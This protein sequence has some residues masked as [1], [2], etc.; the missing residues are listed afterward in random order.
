MAKLVVNIGV[1][2]FELYCI[3]YTIPRRKDDFQDMYMTNGT[4]FLVLE[5][6]SLTLGGLYGI[7]SL[8]SLLLIVTK[9]NMYYFV[10]LNY[11]PKLRK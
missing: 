7:V 2:V 3:L 10:R 5:F 9:I 11:A 4:P 6:L 8:E 1:L